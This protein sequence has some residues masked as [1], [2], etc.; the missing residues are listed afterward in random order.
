MEKHPRNSGTAERH[1]KKKKRSVC[2]LAPERI[3]VCT[4]QLSRLRVE[5]FASVISRS[6]S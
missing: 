2:P 5:I 3:S 1:F 4:F 6:G